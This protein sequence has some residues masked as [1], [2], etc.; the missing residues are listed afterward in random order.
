MKIKDKTKEQFHSL[1]LNIPGIVYRCACDKDWTMQYI[2]NSVEV[3]TGY[4]P[5]DFIG[6]KIRTYPLVILSPFPLLKN[7]MF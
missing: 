3:I 4:T 5:S 6:N 2:S 1:V 7:I